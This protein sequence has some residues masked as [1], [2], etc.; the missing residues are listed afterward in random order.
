MSEYIKAL[1]KSDI[2]EKEGK[3]VEVGGQSVAIFN[4]DGEFCAIDNTCPHRG[5][6]LGEGDLE[7]TVVTC[8]WHGHQFDVTTGQ[9]PMIPGEK[10]KIFPCKVEGENV[11][12]E[13]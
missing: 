13:V 1:N 6:P 2:P 5:G 10:V 12:V 8:P 7:G 11:L 4:I 9:S 3:A